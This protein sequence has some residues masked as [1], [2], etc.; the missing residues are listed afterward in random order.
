MPGKQDTVHARHAFPKGSII[1]REG[2][3]G[4][5]AFLIQSGKV[6]VSVNVAGSGLRRIAALGPGEI[7]GEMAFV[8]DGPRSAT[9]EALEDTV[10]VVITRNILDEK[11]ARSDPTIRALVPMLMKR[12]LRGNDTMVGKE[13]DIGDMIETVKVL[14]SSIHSALPSPYRETMEKTVRSKLE[15]L[16]ESLTTFK[17]KYMTVK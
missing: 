11:L 17:E 3:N 10:V 4:D 1:V 5:C 7:F 2:E 14:Y 12:I 15:E 16:L 13:G 9:V 6:S 8:F